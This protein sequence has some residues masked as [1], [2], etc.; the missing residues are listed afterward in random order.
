MPAVDYSPLPSADYVRSLSRCRIRLPRDEEYELA[1]R[2]AAGDLPA[3]QALVE[4]QL[5]Y[6]VKLANDAH[7][8]CLSRGIYSITHD[9]LIAEGNL[10][11]LTIVKKFDPSRDARLSTMTAFVVKQ[12][13]KHFIWK[14]CSIIV[15][16]SN[17]SNYSARNLEQ[18][19]RVVHIVPLNISASD[20]SE[21]E[22]DESLACYD[23][24]AIAEIDVCDD[25]AYTAARLRYEIG[26]L[27]DR[28]RIVI[29]RRRIMGEKLHEVGDL[30]GITKERV[31]QIESRAMAK[32]REKLADCE[33]LV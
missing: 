15:R 14:H 16:A 25:R 2:S 13:L 11:L 4:S 10:A 22:A 9:D 1:R 20:Q 32:L 5:P 17:P 28:E 3:F 18:A 29:H 33:G 8:I 12:K 21:R 23:D 26:M 30:L 31:R 6:V 24:E 19:A 7:R 27:P